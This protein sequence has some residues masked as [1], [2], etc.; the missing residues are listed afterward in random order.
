[1]LG[2]VLGLGAQT[3]DLTILATSDIHN[4]YL[5]YDY[6]T[7]MATEQTGLVRIATGIKEIRSRTP[8]VL[9]FD[10]GDLIQGNPFGEFLAK[11]PPREGEISPIMNLLNTM[12]YDAMVVGNHEFNFGLPYL[13]AV[14]RGAIFPVLGANVVTY[15]TQAP[16]FRPY[17]ILARNFVDRD[18]N[19]QSL[20]VGVLGLTTPQIVT[21]DGALLR[22]KVRTLDGY[23]TARRYVPEMKA[24]GADIVVVLGHTGIQDFP[25]KGGGGKF[26]PLPY[27]GP[28]H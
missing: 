11:N 5:D 17:V 18:G 1:L 8:N 7:D 28:R 9:L 4:N 6:F 22:G 10:N 15:F 27:P 25:R 13:N 12:G 21:W 16:Y 23:E 19:L 2:L 14:I 20:R 26:R 3:V 24:A